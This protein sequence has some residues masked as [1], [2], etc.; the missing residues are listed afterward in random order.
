MKFYR[1]LQ[2]IKAMS[3]DLDDTLYDNR[4]VIR[5]LTREVTEWFHLHHPVSATRPES[6]WLEIKKQLAQQDRWLLSDLALW[7]QRTTQEGLVRL[8]YSIEQA[9]CAAKELME[10]VLQLRSDFTVPKQTH[11]VMVQLAE[12]MPLVAI[13]NGNVDLKRIGIE[14]YFS[15]V[16][17]AG[18]DGWA[19]PAADMFVKAANHLSLPS[20]QILHVGD[21]LTTDVAGAK[22]NGF[23]AC[24]FN[25]QGADL[26]KDRHARTLPDIEIHQLDSLLLL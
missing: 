2:P 26:S 9:E 18:R 10:V 24:W 21:H 23:Q 15:L 16:L 17:K 25:D 20:Q 13:T 6:W 3:F 5:R 22:L 12:R 8:G 1:G 4:P 14:D 11:D 19:K 7:R